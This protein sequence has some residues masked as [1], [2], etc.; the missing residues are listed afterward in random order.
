MFKIAPLA[1]ALALTAV[2]TPVWAQTAD[3]ATTAK[4]L[5]EGQKRAVLPEFPT[6]G[7]GQALVV[8]YRHGNFALIGRRSLYFVND[9]N[10]AKLWGTTYTA[11]LVPAGSYEFAQ[12]W[13]IDISF[14]QKMKMPVTWESGKTYGYE[15]DTDSSLGY[16][17]IVFKTSVTGALEIPDLKP[18]AK[19]V[20]AMNV[21]KITPGPS[22]TPQPDASGADTSS[23]TTSGK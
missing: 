21:E 13:P 8:I 14:G 20:P 3:P 15:Q 4:R 2:A 6:P 5:C 7:E 12:R 11:F 23:S 10:V 16:Q 17:T 1:A 22:L 19:C 9:V 18:S